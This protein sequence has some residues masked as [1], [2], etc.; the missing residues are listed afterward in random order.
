MNLKALIPNSLTMG[1]L[2]GGS[3]VCWMAASGSDLGN[4]V[5]AGIWLT[6][7]F[8]DLLD[9]LVARKLGVDGP[10]GVQ[11]DSLADLVTGGLAPAFVSYRLITDSAY[12]ISFFTEISPLIRALPW[13]IAIAAAY[14]LARYN[15]NSEK[16]KGQKYFEGLPAPAAGLFWMGMIVWI[17]SVHPTNELKILSIVA[18]LGLL[19]LPLF[20]VLK[21]GFFSLKEWGDD[22]NFDKIR[23]VFI[24]LSILASAGAFIAWNNVFAAA[25]LCVL[26]YS[27]F[28]F[29][30][31]PK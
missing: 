2:L 25:P 31:A 24:A 29:V 30:L 19:L 23:L 20:M 21:R 28:A 8:C 26:L 6:A 4:G 16:R 10:M 11:L 13:A 18:G 3:Y 15:V 7:M 5:V 1:N 9:G 27:C 12:E 22:K 14:R 17:D